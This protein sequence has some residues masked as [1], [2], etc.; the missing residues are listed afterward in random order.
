MDLMERM[1]VK[2]PVRVRLGLG[3]VDGCGCSYMEKCSLKAYC[4]Q[5]TMLGVSGIHKEAFQHSTSCLQSGGG[6]KIAQVKQLSNNAC[7]LEGVSGSGSHFT[8]H[9]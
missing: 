3:N 2:A 9:L 6:G 1:H 5:S 8:R 4:A 7:L